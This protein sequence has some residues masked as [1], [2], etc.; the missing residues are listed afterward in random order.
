MGAT[1]VVT[2]DGGTFQI[3]S[4]TFI[5]QAN[6]GI[7]VAAGGGAIDTQGFNFTW[8]GPIADSVQQGVGTE[9]QPGVVARQRPV[10]VEERV[11][12]GGS[13][14]LSGGEALQRVFGP[15]QLHERRGCVPVGVAAGAEPRCDHELDV[16]FL[17]A[18]LAE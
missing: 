1:A 4:S 6:R 14:A 17:E 15:L 7:T 18:P 9:E 11:G 5:S 16:G 13:G 10:V 12:G 8:A 2:L 3:D